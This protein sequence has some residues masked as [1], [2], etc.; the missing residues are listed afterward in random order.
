[1]QTSFT[2]KAAPTISGGTDAIYDRLT[3]LSKTGET[4]FRFRN[5]DF[6]AGLDQP[7]IMRVNRTVNKDDSM[8]GIV[9]I[10][11]VTNAP[12]AG[13]PDIVDSAWIAVR[14]A[15][16]SSVNNVFNALTHLLATMGTAG[17]STTSVVGHMIAGTY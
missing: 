8:Q 10:D 7:I 17:N 9:R 4:L 14:R 16:N 15:P 3:Q 5:A 13:D 1:M 6:N 12:V 11:Y 2:I